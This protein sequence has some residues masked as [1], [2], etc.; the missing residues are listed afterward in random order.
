MMICDNFTAGAGGFWAPHRPHRT[1]TSH[2]LVQKI[3]LN[4]TYIYI[5]TY[6]YIYIYTYTFTYIYIYQLFE[7]YQLF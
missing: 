6:T 1:D 4:N 5:Y 2:R 7:Q 3:C